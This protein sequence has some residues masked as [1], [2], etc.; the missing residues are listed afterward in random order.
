MFE[1]LSNLQKDI[2]SQAA[3]Y[4]E[5]VDGEVLFH[6]GDVGTILPAVHNIYICN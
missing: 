6:Q 5:Y 1:K 3:G 4:E 2:L